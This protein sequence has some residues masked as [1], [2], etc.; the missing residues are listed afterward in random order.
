M[1]LNAPLVND[2]WEVDATFLGQHGFVLADSILS[3]A[4]CLVI[5]VDE[6]TALVS[7]RIF[8]A[9]LF[10]NQDC[11]QPIIPIDV[12]TAVLSGWNIKDAKD[13]SLKAGLWGVVRVRTEVLRALPRALILGLRVAPRL[14][15]AGRGGQEGGLALALYLALGVTHHAARSVVASGARSSH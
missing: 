11:Q 6:S 9:A 5:A 15:A 3:K 14:V 12:P 2:A 4:C 13:L 10:P 8:N 1:R 7:V